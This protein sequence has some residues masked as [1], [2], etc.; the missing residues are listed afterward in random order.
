M[1]P[2]N[3]NKA[4]MTGLDKA[5]IQKIISEN[6]SANYEQHSRKQ[7]ER[8]D[9]RVEQNRKIGTGDGSVCRDFGAG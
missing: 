6:T 4:G 1:L 5:N 3:D 7:K 9:R 8:I 2:F